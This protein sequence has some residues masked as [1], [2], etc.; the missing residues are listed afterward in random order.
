MEENYKEPKAEF[1]IPL[2]VNDLITQF[3]AAYKNDD[4]LEQSAE[5]IEE[6]IKYHIN[7]IKLFIQR[8][9]IDKLKLFIKNIQGKF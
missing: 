8:H 9:Y 5:S 6:N 4:L 2:V 1:L 3:S 7:K